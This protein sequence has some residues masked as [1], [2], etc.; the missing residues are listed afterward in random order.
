MSCVP[1]AATDEV[2]RYLKAVGAVRVGFGATALFA[3]DVAMRLF[4]MKPGNP[5]ARAWGAFLGSRAITIGLYSLAATRRGRQRDAVLLNTGCELF[6]AAV[7][8]QEIRHGRPWGVFNVVGVAFNA[9]S[10]VVWARA[11]RL[12]RA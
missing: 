11:R 4:G 2:D 8:A 3:P 9:V 7:L 6:D 1:A 10:H 5:D 12:T